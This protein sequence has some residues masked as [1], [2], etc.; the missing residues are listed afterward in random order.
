M[1]NEDSVFPPRKRPSSTP[2]ASDADSA[3]E[4]Y[5]D[6]ERQKLRLAEIEDELNDLLQQQEVCKKRV[7]G[8]ESVAEVHEAQRELNLLAQQQLQLTNERSRLQA[9]KFFGSIFTWAWLIF[10]KKSAA[11]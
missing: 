2:A 9:G 7:S 1:E 6:P 11:E 5:D 8:A 10:P 3:A 4:L